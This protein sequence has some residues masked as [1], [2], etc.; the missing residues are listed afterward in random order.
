MEGAAR[1]L[2]NFFLEKSVS[3]RFIS[4]ELNYSLLG[5]RNRFTDIFR[6]C[7]LYFLIFQYGQATTPAY[8]YNQAS[9]PT[10]GGFPNQ[11][12]IRGTSIA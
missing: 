3:D 12:N 10:F 11:A 4:G 9:T 6:S 7:D 1:H 2:V 5:F 8:A